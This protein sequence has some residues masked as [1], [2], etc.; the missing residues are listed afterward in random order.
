MNTDQTKYHSSAT[1][2]VA[3][4]L[5][6]MKCRLLLRK[7]SSLKRLN[8]AVEVGAELLHACADAVGSLCLVKECVEL[9]EMFGCVVVEKLLQGD[10]VDIRR[11]K[12]DI[13]QKDC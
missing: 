13:L 10:D 1:A 9:E 8:N 3:L 12:K 5:P 11:V 6:S 7:L 4:E 2:I